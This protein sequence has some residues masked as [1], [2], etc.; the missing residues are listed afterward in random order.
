MTKDTEALDFSIRIGNFTI[1][2][3]LNGDMD[4]DSSDMTITHHGAL[5][6]EDGDVDLTSSIVEAG[7]AMHGEMVAEII[8]GLCR[9]IHD[10]ATPASD[11]APVACLPE[12]IVRLHLGQRRASNECL[13]NDGHTIPDGQPLYW[14]QQMG[15]YDD[16]DPY[17]LAHAI[18]QA[19]SDS[20]WCAAC[21]DREHRDSVAQPPIAQSIDPVAGEALLHRARRIY[22]DYGAASAEAKGCV[23]DREWI[24]KVMDGEAD[25]THGVK[26][27]LAALKGP[28]A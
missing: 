5:C 17:C 1:S 6:V 11:V 21:L 12:T 2:G 19:E 14:P 23:A 8:V 28:S 3:N 20:G 16:N 18:D 4:Y 25:D 26:I 22:A 7:Y 27:A 10:A 15:E 13:C 24:D 9:Q